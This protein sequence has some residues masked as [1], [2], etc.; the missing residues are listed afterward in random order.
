MDVITDIL[1]TFGGPMAV[2]RDTGTPPQTVSDWKKNGIP[3]WRR[4]SLL[5]LSPAE[6]KALSP[7]A[8]AYLQSNER[9]P[10]EQV[11]A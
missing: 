2:A 8:L 6:G 5:D 7:R 11:A 1:D 9:T 10:V 3:P 4:K